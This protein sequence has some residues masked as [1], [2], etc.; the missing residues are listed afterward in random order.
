[1]E[2]I[3]EDPFGRRGVLEERGGF[4]TD[5]YLH[6][7]VFGWICLGTFVKRKVYSILRTEHFLWLVIRMQAVH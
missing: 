3:L 6:L 4:L 2:G 7:G 1:M 5:M